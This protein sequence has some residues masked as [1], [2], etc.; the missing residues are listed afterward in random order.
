MR[1][2]PCIIMNYGMWRDARHACLG[3]LNNFVRTCTHVYAWYTMS[4]I[5]SVN[6]SGTGFQL[7]LRIRMMEHP[8]GFN[9]QIETTAVSA[10]SLP[11]VPLVLKAMPDLPPARLL[12]RLIACTPPASPACSA[13]NRSKSAVPVK[14]PPAMMMSHMCPC[15]HD[16]S[17]F[18]S[19]SRMRSIPSTI[20]IGQSRPPRTPWRR[21]AGGTP[22]T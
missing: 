18:E 5:C 3:C 6:E 17:P 14:C 11:P 1:H 21:T 10:R 22:A 9:Q 12:P 8:G 20:W 7:A 2:I 16:P 15:R 13:Q 4:S 19:L